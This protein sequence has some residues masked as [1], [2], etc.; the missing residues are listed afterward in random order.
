MPVEKHPGDM[1]ISG[2]INQTGR[3]RCR[4]QKV[5]SDSMVAQI[6]EL[7]R[8]AQSSKASIQRLADRIA[9][10]FV[11]IVILIAL[12]SLA[13][14]G[15]LGADWGTGLWAMVSVLIVACPCALGLATPTA[16][17][18]GTGIGAQRGILIKNARVLE[19]AGHVSAIVL[20][21]TGTLT[22]GRPTVTD[23]HPLAPGFDERQ[24]LSLA[25][26]L[27]SASEHPIARAIVRHAAEK[28]LPTAPVEDFQS[29]TAF[30]VSGRVGGRAILVGRPSLATDS[31]QF[32]DLVEHL[33]SQGKAVVAL[34]EAGRTL[35]LLAVADSLKPGAREAVAELRAL[36]LEPIL[37]TGDHEA[38]AR[39]IASQVGIE[40]WMAGV[41]PAD[42][43]KRIRELQ[44]GASSGPRLV[45][46]VGD[47]IND[48]PALAA[49][50]IGIALGAGTE[51]AKEAGDVVLVSSDLA[52]IPRAIRLGR[53]TMRR[54]YA[55]LFWA[56]AYNIVLIP[57]AAS[58]LLTPMFAAGAMALSSVSVVGNALW[59][60]RVPLDR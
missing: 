31:S 36:G 30:G 44:A 11:P 19:R 15:V 17:M 49:A 7:V 45:A 55:G 6:V 38:A 33:Q 52:T 32:S 9:G 40:Q 57:V 27:E 41:L 48:G 56:F 42:K 59:L 28:R 54:I 12:L 16:I 34:I 43:E 25:A 4:A 47:G 14:W 22:A 23:I 35:G 21:K 13:G 37:L 60:K 1:I 5:G 10:V 20:D 39:T 3:L 24:V 29:M 18:V 2:T 58:G 46:M 8:R 26:S 50:D 53:A 51:I